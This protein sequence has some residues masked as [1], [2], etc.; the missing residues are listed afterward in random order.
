[1]PRPGILRPA[2]AHALPHRSAAAALQLPQVCQ[3]ALSVEPSVQPH[4][5]PQGRQAK[6]VPSSGRTRRGGGG[7][8]GQSRTG[9]GTRHSPFPFP[10]Q[11]RHRRIH[12]RSLCRLHNLVAVAFH[13]VLILC[14]SQEK[15][16][17]V[18]V[19]KPSTS[20]SG[21]ACLKSEYVM[22]CVR[23]SLHFVHVGENPGAHG[24]RYF[25]RGWAHAMRRTRTRRARAGDGESGADCR[26]GVGT[27]CQRAW[28]GAQQI[29]ERGRTLFC[30]AKPPSPTGRH[31]NGLS[32]TSRFRTH[33]VRS[34]FS[35]R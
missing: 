5:L 12:G 7:G 13:L 33:Q 14:V 9:S 22:C 3:R 34:S 30:Q 28:A 1:M 6:H 4:R 21:F 31:I 15:S 10:R 29:E 18:P 25:E 11:R 17:P 32:A 26:S 2:R 20:T 23:P 16:T 24:A 35:G 27:A 19:P 8:G